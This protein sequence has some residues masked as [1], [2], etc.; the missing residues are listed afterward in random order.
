MEQVFH[1][2]KKNVYKKSTVTVLH[3]AIFCS[4]SVSVCCH[5]NELCLK[6]FQNVMHLNVLKIVQHSFSYTKMKCDI[7]N[8]EFLVV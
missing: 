6:N 5:G 8:S 4:E 7:F 2:I 1:V 3:K